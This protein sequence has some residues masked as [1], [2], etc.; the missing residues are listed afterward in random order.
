[1]GAAASA[2]AIIVIGGK[3]KVHYNG[4]QEILFLT[5]HGYQNIYLTDNCYNERN[6]VGRR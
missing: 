3:S 4:A 5:M 6:D 1:M 2:A